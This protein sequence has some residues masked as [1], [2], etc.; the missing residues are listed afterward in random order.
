[1]DNIVP[2]LLAIVGGA[3][4]LAMASVIVS[5]Q[6]QTPAVLQASGSALSTVI[7]AAVSPVTGATGNAGI[8]SN[9]NSAFSSA[10]GSGLL[11]QFGGLTF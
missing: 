8:A 2:G 4:T 1:M 11:N 6:A 3:F 10:W 5:K 9:N 7:S